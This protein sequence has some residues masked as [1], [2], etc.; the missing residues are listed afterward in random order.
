MAWNVDEVVQQMTSSKQ[1]LTYLLLQTGLRKQI[2]RRLKEYHSI[3]NSASPLQNDRKAKETIFDQILSAGLPPEELT[4]SRLGSEASILVGAG[5]ET[6]AKALDVLAFH[7][8][9]QPSI[10]EK[11]RAELQHAHVSYSSTLSQLESIPYLTAVV[12]EGLRCANGITTRSPRVIRETLAYKNWNIPPH[13]VVSM[14]VSDVLTNETI[15]PEPDR[16]DPERWLLSDSSEAK[17]LDQ[18]LVVF[19][20]GPR[21]CV[22][23]ELAKAELYACTAALVAQFDLELFDTVFERDVKAKRD[24]FIPKP[25][26][27]SRGIRIK[28]RKRLIEW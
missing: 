21:Q 4:L 13:T 7:I 20:R 2:E 18:Y 6:T 22:G 23:M 15:F 19:N 14:T 27:D 12:K 16:F 17:K 3:K 26:P 24:H 28:V 10:L 9:D 5:S 25:G 8:L 1:P 11:L